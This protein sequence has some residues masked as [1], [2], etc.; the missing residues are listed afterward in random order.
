[1]YYIAENGESEAIYDYSCTLSKL[2]GIQILE[3]QPFTKDEI[4]M[5]VN[6]GES[7]I[8]ILQREICKSSYS[9]L[10]DEQVTWKTDTLIQ[11]AID[12]GEKTVCKLDDGIKLHRLT[13]S[14]GI[15]LVYTNSTADKELYETITFDLKSMKIVN[16]DS[17]RVNIKCGPGETKHI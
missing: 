10:V 15:M 4:S 3:P 6:P 16:C 9:Q 1:M 8:R 14:G 13:H 2:E 12:E 17:N 5:H 11:K 7:E